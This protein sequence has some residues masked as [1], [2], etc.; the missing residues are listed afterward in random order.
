MVI[1]VV[2]GIIIFVIA[3]NYKESTLNNIGPNCELG[4]CSEVN[5]KTK[6]WQTYDNKEYG[7]AVK[8]PSELKS[9]EKTEGSGINFLGELNGKNFFLNFEYISQNTLNLMGITACEA[10]PESPACEHFSYN[11]LN[12]I[13]SWNTENEGMYSGSRAE[14]LKPDGGKIVISTLYSPSQEI[15]TLFRLMLSTFKFL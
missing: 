1:I 4:K 5:T 2:L 9:Q 11:G 6:D 13:I 7:F 12:F 10:H 14:I 15:K 8:F 3:K